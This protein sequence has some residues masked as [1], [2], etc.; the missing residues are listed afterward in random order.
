MNAAFLYSNRLLFV[1]GTPTLL[2]L[3]LTDRARFAQLLNVAITSDW[4][5]GEY[6]EGAMRFFID[7][8]ISG[9]EEVIGWYNWY[10]ITYPT[11]TSPATLVAGA[12]Y[13]GPPSSDGTVEIGYSVSKEWRR[14]GIATEIVST[15]TAHAWKQPE[16]RRIIAHTLPSNEA[17]IKALTKNGFY[18]F[19]SD[20][21]EKL[22]FELLPIA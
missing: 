15:L 17:S 4:P 12:G 19:E 13:F 20:D 16:I 1:A 2:N 9:Q 11:A 22:C 3:E 18:S 14:Q 6:D 7:Q 21:P 8:L 5:P 10:V